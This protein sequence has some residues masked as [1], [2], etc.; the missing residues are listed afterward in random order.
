MAAELEGKDP[1]DPWN[2]AALGYV[3]ALGAET[4]VAYSSARVYYELFD[5]VPCDD[6]IT[7]T[8]MKLQVGGTEAALAGDLY[9]VSLYARRHING[10]NLATIYQDY[11]DLPDIGSVGLDESWRYWRDVTV[12]ADHVD[13]DPV[14]CVVLKVEA[15]ST[16]SYDRANTDY[17]QTYADQEAYADPPMWGVRIL[18]ASVYASPLRRDVTPERAVEFIV[19]PWWANERC[20]FP[21][22]SGVE[23]DQLTFDTIPK[24]RMEALL[25]IDELLDW[26][27]EI[28]RTDVI[29]KKPV[30]EATARD[31]EVYVVSLADPHLTGSI[32][33]DMNECYRG[34]RAVFTNKNEKPREEIAWADSEYLG[35]EPRARVRQLPEAVRSKKQAASIAQRLA[36]QHAE[37]PIAGTWTFSGTAPVASGEERDALLV[38]PGELLR[39][40]DA[41]RTYRRLEREISTVVLSPLEHS[42]EVELGA[43]SRKIEKVLA[44]MATRRPR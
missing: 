27:L 10:A 11:I 42:A 1:R 19:S 4:D 43:K 15:L 30:T 29:Y 18:E 26:D 39:V 38:R 36:T 23:C 3:H 6:R 7:D 5:G 12:D 33:P 9:R 2:A 32:T 41:P 44:R 16:A 20:L 22:D 34:V 8:V 24:T 17:A 13:D 28:N 25:E 21:D 35:D 37:P 14:R 31:D 40:Q